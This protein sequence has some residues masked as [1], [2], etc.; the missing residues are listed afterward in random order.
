[1]LLFRIVKKVLHVMQK[2]QNLTF[3]ND[4]FQWEDAL[5]I[6]TCDQLNSMN[7]V[8]FTSCFV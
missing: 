3:N 5:S 8:A 7:V 4:H 1:M 2:E 6:G